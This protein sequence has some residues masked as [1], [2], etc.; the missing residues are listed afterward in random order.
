VI[1]IQYISGT[2]WASASIQVVD[3]VI[4]IDVLFLLGGCLMEVIQQ[5]LLVDD[6]KSIYQTGPATIFLKGPFFLN[7]NMPRYC[8]LYSYIRVYLCVSLFLFPTYFRNIIIPII[9]P[10]GW[11]GPASIPPR[12]PPPAMHLRT[13]LPHDEFPGMGPRREWP[14]GSSHFGWPQIRLVRWLNK[15]FF[16]D[17]SKGISEGF[18]KY[19]C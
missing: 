11:P 17:T 12:L 8:W 13:G 14:G 7:N 6:K 19:S 10:V 18:N 3:Q 9:H 16:G 15:P 5:P 4:P 1:P 2:S